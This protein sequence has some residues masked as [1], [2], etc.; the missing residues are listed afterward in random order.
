M[1]SDAEFQSILAA[2]QASAEW[3]WTAI[4]RAYAPAALRYLKG[5]GATEPEDLLGEVFLQLVRGLNR[6][7]GSESEF[8]SWIFIIARNRLVDEWRRRGRQPVDVVSA[9]ELVLAV[10]TA[11]GEAAAMRRLSDATVLE[12]L[13]YLTHNQR[14][15]LYL[16][17]FADLT[18]EQ[19]ARAMGRSPG[20]VKALQA[21]ALARIQREMSKKAVTL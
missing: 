2:A 16:R 6:F 20:S 17:L 10:G 21:R 7:E 11:D 5:H 1:H 12:I 15:V 19:T 9:D 13:G 14:D 8:R 18:I 4:Y 3:A